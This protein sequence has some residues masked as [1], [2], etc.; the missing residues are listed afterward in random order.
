MDLLQS[1]NYRS[2]IKEIIKD[3]NHIR[4]YQ[5]KLSK[6]MGVDGAFMS[7]V[8]NGH[9]QL[10][11]DQGASLSEYLKWPRD[12]RLY[13][14]TLVNLER[15]SSPALKSILREELAEI[16]KRIESFSHRF[17][18]ATQIE[19]E[20]HQLYY[21]A[22]YFGAIHMLLML[23]E[24]QS[25]DSL[26][27]RLGLSRELVQSTLRGLEAMGL[28]EFKES[29][30]ESLQTNLHLRPES[31]WATVLHSSWRQKSIMKIQERNSESLNFIGVHAISKSD[32][33]QIKNLIRE[34][35][36]RVRDIAS[37]SKEDDVYTFICDFFQI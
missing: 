34:S 31:P 18:E 9:V 23:P 2:V 10:T 33:A 25:A 24:Y 30:W 19:G 20:K 36:E 12:E 22:W 14:L 4:G 16:R 7:R 1:S 21:S 5:G 37:R 8:L 28:A 17:Q 13:F 11:P 32:A 3:N 35:V 29:R 6:A 26:A 15:A 27:Q